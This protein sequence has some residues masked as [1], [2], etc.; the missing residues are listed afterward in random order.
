MVRAAAHVEAD[1]DL[2][3]AQRRRRERGLDR[4]GQMIVQAGLHLADEL[5]EAQHHAEFVGLDAEEAGQAPQRDERQRDQRD[6]AAAEIARQ[7]AAQLVLAA[8][9]EFFEIGR[10]RP[11]RCCGP[12]PH[13]P[14]DPE[15]H[16]PPDWLLHGIKSLLD[17]GCPAGLVGGGYRGAP[18]P[19]QRAVMPRSAAL[20][21]PR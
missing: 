19:L 10:L 12:E 8:A 6:A 13:G 17:A 15:P 18:R 7:Q 11:L 2:V 9:Q 20:L 16:G 14:R 1:V 4:I 5:A 3:D 21:P